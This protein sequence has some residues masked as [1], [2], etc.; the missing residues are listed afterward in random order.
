MRLTR[1]SLLRTGVAAFAAPAFDGLAR[2]SAALAQ[3]SAPARQWK[4]GLSLFGELK[5]AEDFKQ[6]DYVNASAPKTG[7]ARMIA[8]GCQGNVIWN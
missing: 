2:S 6:F 5:Y 8:F 7:A 1:R 3:A 4:H